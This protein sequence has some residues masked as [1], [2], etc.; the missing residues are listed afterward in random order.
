[1]RTQNKILN[2]LITT[3]LIFGMFYTSYRYPFMINDSTT[4][5]YYSDTPKWLAVGKYLFF[6]FLLLYVISYKLLNKQ[7]LIIYRPLY[8]LSYMT[9]SVVPMFYGLMIKD[10]MLVE[11][12]VF[13]LIPA[14]L[15]LFSS[16]YF[17]Y[18]KLNKIIVFII[19]I[20]IASEVIQLLLFLL[21]NRLPALAYDNSIS[22]RFGS[23]LDDPNGFGVLLAFF[24]GFS[25]SFF[26]GIKRT[27][28]LSLL[29]IFLILTQS[30]TAIMSVI[31]AVIIFIIIF[32]IRFL[33]LIAKIMI[34]TI[35][36]IVTILIV[37]GILQ[38]K[39]II[40]IY[41]KFLET[42]IGSISQHL[43]VLDIVGRLKPIQLI[44]LEPKGWI[45][46]SGYINILGNFGVVYLMLYI[47]VGLFAIYKYY[48]V[49]NDKQFPTERKAFASGAFLFLITT[50]IATANLPFD[51]IFPIN[52]FLTLVLGLSSSDILF[53]NN[54]SKSVVKK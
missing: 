39:K 7:E 28:L 15:H 14:G 24:I 23:F 35:I 33:R 11:T 54:N 47:M 27:L 40:E 21:F 17:S 13:F 8:L 19:Y 44:G 31:L 50:Y 37:I 41:N 46:E 18:Q 22:V 12:G 5:P 25:F 48:R 32:Y 34:K 51:Q 20:A 36:P 29:F 49:I 9:L 43:D 16:N 45:G 38:Y 53:G 3:V 1:M 52:L 4:S 10:F 26:K 30:L 2:L 6:G 42:K